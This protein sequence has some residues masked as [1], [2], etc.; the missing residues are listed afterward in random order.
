MTADSNTR[1]PAAEAASVKPFAA[2]SEEQRSRTNRAE[3]VRYAISEGL[4]DRQQDNSTRPAGWKSIK[5]RRVEDVPVIV[6]DVR[7]RADEAVQHEGQPRQNNDERDHDSD[8]HHEPP[9]L[10][11]GRCWLL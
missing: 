1:F 10:R 4:L 3:L 8:V 9:L 5:V 6:M 11:L 2:A 7:E